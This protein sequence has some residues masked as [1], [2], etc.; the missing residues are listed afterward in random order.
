MSA[1][2]FCASGAEGQT[3]KGI[4]PMKRSEARQRLAS[5][6]WFAQLEPAL[7]TAVF[8][9]GRIVA[10]ERGAA[11]FRPGDEPGG[12]YGVV[13]GG[14]VI[15][16]TGRDGLPAAGHIMRRGAW[17]GYG[18]VT[19]RQKRTLMAEANEPSTI[20]HVPLSRLEGLRIEY[21]SLG[22]AAAHLAAHGETAMLSVIADLLIGNTD[23]RLA[24]VLLRVT[25][26]S[27]DDPWSD[28]RGVSLTQQRLADLAAVSIHT[29]ARFVDRSSQQ[30]WITWNYGR[31][32]ILDADG[33]GEFAAGRRSWTTQGTRPLGSN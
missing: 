29:V 2:E 33:L 14:M 32:R 1:S 28:P 26:E 11:L 25:G 6:G 16:T 20:L 22:P 21:P 13:D 12:I 23:R 9:A 19:F 15:S 17:F 8:D 3:G 7:A 4:R 30:G 27:P 24:A 5:R 10:L 18:S 31:V